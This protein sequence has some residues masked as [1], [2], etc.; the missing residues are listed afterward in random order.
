MKIWRSIFDYGHLLSRSHFWLFIIVNFISIFVILEIC[1]FLENNDFTG[2]FYWLFILSTINAGIQRMNDIKKPRYYLFVPLYNI[3]LLLQKGVVN[4]EEPKTHVSG[5]DLIKIFL[6]SI[7]IWVLN[8][9]LVVALYDSY[10]MNDIVLVPMFS[11][12]WTLL[13]LIIF[14]IQVDHFKKE[15]SNKNLFTYFLQFILSSS[16]ITLLIITQSWNRN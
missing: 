11:G 2:L 8:V 12:F 16:I 15:I 10:S 9:I 14:V 3:F 13:F 7:L 1:E 5:F 6:Y 4:E